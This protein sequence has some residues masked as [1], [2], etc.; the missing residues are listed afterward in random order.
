[1]TAVACR[2]KAIARVI[3]L[4][5]FVLLKLAFVLQIIVFVIA[6]GPVCVG[7]EPANESSKHSQRLF[8][9]TDLDGWYVY[10]VET[11]YENPGVFNVVDHSIRVAGGKGEQG[12]FG[13]LI[14]KND[15]ENYCLEFDYKWG[16]KT[17]GRRYGKARDA[18]VLLHCIGP[19]GPGPWMT[20]YEFQ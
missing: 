9:G 19:N 20:S 1:C 10:T 5:R 14:T 12:Y 3:M 15:Y 11:Q 2:L 18:G 8:N 16:E 13:G 17:F 6:G 7:V 4:R